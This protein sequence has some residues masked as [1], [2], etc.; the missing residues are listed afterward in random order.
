MLKQNRG[1]FGAN[2]LTQA[3]VNSKGPFSDSQ[4]GLGG[5]G[6]AEGERS[7]N[8]GYLSDH[9]P[10]SPGKSFPTQ[11]EASTY[12]PDPRVLRDELAAP[13]LHSSQAFSLP[14]STT[15]S[16]LGNPPRAPSSN[17]L[18]LQLQV[19]PTHP[20]YTVLGTKPR[21]SC[22]LG[23]YGP[24]SRATFSAPSRLSIFGERIL[25]M[26][27]RLAPNLSSSCLSFWMLRL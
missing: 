23:N 7:C 27:P 13:L 11:A 17:S 25:L 2:F 3:E 14:N 1:G 5:S 10:R 18:V 9:F 21:A 16:H 22:K 8:P 12:N 19:C 20:V 26:Q 6:L 24:T 15:L 4:N